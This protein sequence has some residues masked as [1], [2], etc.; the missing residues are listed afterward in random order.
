[1]EN[2]DKNYKLR[3]L[4]FEISRNPQGVRETL[5]PVEISVSPEEVLC[6][7]QLKLVEGA[8]I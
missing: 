1:M 6:I 4:Y 8:R 5:K 7:R 2:I 3:G